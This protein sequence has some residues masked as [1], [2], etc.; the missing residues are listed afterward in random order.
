MRKNLDFGG[1]ISLDWAWQKAFFLQIDK[2]LQ[3]L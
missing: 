3:D 1:E 2:N